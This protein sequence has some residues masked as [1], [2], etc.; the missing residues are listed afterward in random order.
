MAAL[1]T[2]ATTTLSQ[3][4]GPSDQTFKLASTSG[5]TPGTRL[6][7]DR[8]LTSVVS[9]GDG[10]VTVRRGV[11][12]TAG[13]RHGY[14]TLITIGRADQFFEVDPLGLPPNELP[15]TPYINVLT[16]V[17]WV[18]TGDEQGPGVSGRLWQ[19][20]TTTSTIG[21]LGVRVTTTTP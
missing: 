5:I 13:A 14:N 10:L 21:S 17:V 9:V 6:Y 20:S 18:A 1:A 16:G 4:V 8:E 7:L 3:L 11:D 12:G 2:L 19:Q 15:V